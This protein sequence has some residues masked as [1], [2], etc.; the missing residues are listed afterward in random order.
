MTLEELNEQAMEMIVHSGNG[1][2][3]KSGIGCTL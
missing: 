1:K 2:Y 3:V